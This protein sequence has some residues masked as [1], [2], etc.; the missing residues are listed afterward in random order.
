MTNTTGQLQDSAWTR[1]VLR[2]AHNNIPEENM[3][4][5]VTGRHFD[6]GEALKD[7]ATAKIEAAIS[8]YRKITSARVVLDQQGS[9]AKAEVI[10]HGK[11]INYE[12]ESETFDMYKSIDE[13]IAKI[14]KQL[15]KHFEKVQEHHKKGPKAA[16]TEPEE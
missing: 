14:D 9:R 5:I 10:V 16:Q 4:I 11:N 12:A 3:D 6:V 1:G 13:A 7:H 8:E 15:V 2:P